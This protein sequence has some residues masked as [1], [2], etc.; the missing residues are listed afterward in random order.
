MARFRRGRAI[1]WGGGDLENVG[2]DLVQPAGLPLVKRRTR[3]LKLT[4]GDDLAAGSSC[5]AR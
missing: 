5:L 1:W 3:Y 4:Q 2:K